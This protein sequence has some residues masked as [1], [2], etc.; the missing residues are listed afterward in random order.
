VKAKPDDESPPVRQSL[1]G[2]AG[3]FSS[4]LADDAHRT[5]ALRVMLTER[6]TV[7]LAAAVHA[8]ALS[9]F[10]DDGD[11]ALALHVVTPALRAEG[12]ADTGSGATPGPVIA[13]GQRKPGRPGRR[14]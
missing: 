7:A 10:Y 8:L 3:C 13:R 6:P 12:A 1:K 11:S 9:V 4:A 14:S 2:D 5:A